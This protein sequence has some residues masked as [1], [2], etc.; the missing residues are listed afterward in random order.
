MNKTSRQLA[1]LGMVSR[2][3]RVGEKGT[4][5]P[6][7]LGEAN[8]RNIQWKMVRNTEKRGRDGINLTSCESLNLR[9][10]RRKTGLKS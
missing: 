5:W 9:R 2:R 8:N 10:E 4:K 1:N 7:W 6:C 3:V